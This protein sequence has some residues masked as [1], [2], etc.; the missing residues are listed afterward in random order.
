M[1]AAVEQYCADQAAQQRPITAAMLRRKLDTYDALVIPPTAAFVRQYLAPFAE[2]TVFLR[3]RA[4]QR[5]CV[6]GLTPVLELTV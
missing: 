3:T 2:K 4:E 5:R 6:D 1:A